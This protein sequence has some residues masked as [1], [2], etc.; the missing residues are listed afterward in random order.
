MTLHIA[1]HRATLRERPHAQPTQHDAL[2]PPS[3]AG[4]EIAPPARRAFP[5]SHDAR[6]HRHAKSDAQAQKLPRLAPQLAQFAAPQE[7]HLA[8]PRR[9]G[10]PAD[11]RDRPEPQ[12]LGETC[13]KIEGGG[14]VV[15]H[16]GD[17]GS[18]W[19]RTVT[20]N[21]PTPRPIHFRDFSA[22]ALAA[23]ARD[24]EK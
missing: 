8:Q 22:R 4:R 19:K 18:V 20:L 7:A 16:G 9:L 14:V 10:E 3:P 17:G 23:M 24:F 13:Q 12:G 1:Q 6:P 5:P 11:K 2:H 21:P 15:C